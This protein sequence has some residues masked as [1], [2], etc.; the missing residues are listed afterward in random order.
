MINIPRALF[1]SV[2]E[3]TGMVANLSAADLRALLE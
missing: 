1:E 3:D 2:F